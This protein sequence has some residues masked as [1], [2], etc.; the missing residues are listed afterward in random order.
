MRIAEY[1]WIDAHGELRSKTKT[2]SMNGVPPEWGF[3]GSSTDQADG[4]NS[5]CILKPVKY[6]SDPIRNLPCALVL[7]EV[8]NAD[9]TPGKGNYR[10]RAVDVYKKSKGAIPMFGFEQE[11]TLMKDDKYLG[12]KDEKGL[13][14]LPEQGPFYCGVGEGKEYGSE[15]GEIHMFGCLA[16]KLKWCGKNAE[17][18]PGQHEFQIGPGDPID[19]ADDVW[20]ARY[21]LQKVAQKRGYSVTFDPKPHPELNGAGMH[22]NFSTKLTRGREGMFH[23][24]KIA[25][26]LGLKVVNGNHGIEEGKTY[27]AI[28]FPDCYGSKF[29]DRLTGK[30]E[31]CGFN[32]FKYSVADRTASIRIP[33]HV[34]K[35]GSGYLE[36]RRPCADADPYRV[37]TYIMEATCA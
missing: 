22:T 37:V 13:K 14:K 16:A 10:A 3:D 4:E 5:D 7:C 35:N 11:Y 25:E 9:G 2:I 21:L 19:I 1:I 30:H 18:M 31:T 17:V 24:A 27:D 23:I 36:D 32:K 15:V 6:C 8:Y 33:L 34:E 20:L 28:G 26:M 29:E 12:W